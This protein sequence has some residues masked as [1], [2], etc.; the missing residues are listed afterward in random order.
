[1][2]IRLLLSSSSCS[3]GPEGVEIENE[4]EGEGVLLF[5]FAVSSSSVLSLLSIEAEER[6]LLPA[7]LFPCEAEAPLGVLNGLL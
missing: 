7:V 1:M 4:D 3:V 6:L 5:E 2:C